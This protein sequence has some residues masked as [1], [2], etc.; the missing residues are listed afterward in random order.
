MKA[1]V[2]PYD[3]LRKH[4]EHLDF[5]ECVEC[6]KSI[7]NPVCPQCITDEF[8][9]WLDNYNKLKGKKEM[10]KEVNGFIK[11]HKDFESHSE[12]C[13]SCGNERVFMCPYCFT[14]YLFRVVKRNNPELLPEFLVLFNYDFNHSG[15][16]KEGERLG[17]Y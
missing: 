17:V 15:Y 3:L 9:S 10:I 13:I 5:L 1:V 7:Y 12:N 4:E 16:W 14:R 11:R 6:G 8:V 2:Q